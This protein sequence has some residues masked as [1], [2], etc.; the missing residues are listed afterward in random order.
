MQYLYGSGEAAGNTETVWRAIRNYVL[1]D[2][3]MERRCNGC[4]PNMVLRPGST[5]AAPKTDSCGS[6]P[7]AAV[8]DVDE[9]VLLNLGFESD[10]AA[11]PGRPYDPVRW[12]TWEMAG[13]DKVVATPGAVQ[14]VRDL[15][16]SG[17]TVIF[18]TNRSAANAHWTE[19]ALN[20]AGLGPAKHGET[21]FLAGDDATGSHKDGRRQLIASRWCVI[22][23]GGDQL[24][25]FTDLFNTGLSPAQRRAAVTTGPL[26]RWWGQ[27]W[28]LFPNPVYGTALT[29][30][31][32][33]VFPAD[34]RW[35]APQETK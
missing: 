33:D 10:D 3:I 12:Q 23:M 26:A 11:H 17:V 29:G 19:Q 30:S 35:T 9:T 14:A 22:A 8:F 21:L 31:M 16:A 1:L 4:R 15:R 2:H 25:D 32:D 13:A 27:G 5:L 18:N 28:F 7:L 24:G 6:K 20:D 34:R